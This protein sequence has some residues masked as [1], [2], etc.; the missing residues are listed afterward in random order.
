MRRIP[1]VRPTTAIASLALVLSLGA[2]SLGSDDTA[3]DQQSPDDTSAVGESPS[4]APSGEPGSPE[5][6]G[7]DPDNLPEPVAAAT[8]PARAGEGDQSDATMTV[9]LLGLSREGR[10]VVGQFAFTIDAAA[11]SEPNH[12]YHYLGN[13]GWAPFFIDNTNLKRHRVLSDSSGVIRAQTD[14][15]GG[16]FG[17][18]QTFYAFAVFAAPPEDVTEV[19]VA[20]VDGAPLATGITIQ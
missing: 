1:S 15:Q 13:S 17:P 7:L 10:T 14:Y 4:A 3:A 20:M 16:K 6:A 5:S 19:D 18:G 2:C 12:L 11:G 8:V 9:E